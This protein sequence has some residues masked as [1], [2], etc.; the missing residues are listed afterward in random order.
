MVI[1]SADA[2]ERLKQKV[3]NKQ[4]W[5]LRLGMKPNGCN[6]WSYDLSYLEEPNTSSDAVFYGIIAVD[7]MTFSYV[8]QIS[9]DW[10]EDGLNEYFE[11]KSPQET[12]RCGC[13][14]SFTL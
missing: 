12:A 10:T 5:G 1:V 3:K 7:P 14:E 9:I 8:D 2:L 4:V 13:G 11:I 6:G